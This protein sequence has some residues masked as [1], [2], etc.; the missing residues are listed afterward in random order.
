MWKTVLLVNLINLEKYW[1]GSCTQS[2]TTQTYQEKKRMRRSNCSSSNNN[3]FGLDSNYMAL[4]S[5]LTRLR[6]SRFNYQHLSHIWY[7][8]RII[9]YGPL[10]HIL[11]FEPCLKARFYQRHRDDIELNN[12][13]LDPTSWVINGRDPLSCQCTALR[14]CLLLLNG[15]VYLYALASLQPSAHGTSVPTRRFEEKNY[16]RALLLESSKESNCHRTVADI[17]SSFKVLL[18]WPYT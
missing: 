8:K 17:L 10:A 5:N 14:T 13:L 7:F 6:F 18:K 2:G 3:K 12:P 11:G 4:I 9:N 1:A 15:R 16:H